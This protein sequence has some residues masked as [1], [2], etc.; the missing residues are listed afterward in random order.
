MSRRRSSSGLSANCWLWSNAMAAAD[1]ATHAN[2]D[3]VTAVVTSCGRQDLLARTLRSFLG[4]NT[5]PDVQIIVVEDGSPKRNRDLV[6]KFGNVP[7]RWMATGSWVGQI[8]AI[9]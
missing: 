8:R 4:T 2:I 6:A 9:D 7:I 3:R 5:F 1:R